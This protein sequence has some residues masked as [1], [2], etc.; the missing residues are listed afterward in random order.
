[1]SQGVAILFIPPLLAVCAG[2]FFRRTASRRILI[3][4]GVYFALFFA[5]GWGLDRQCGFND[6]SFGTCHV[7]PNALIGV[8]SIWHLYTLGA[9]MI[10][11]PVLLVW[12]VALEM[13]LRCTERPGG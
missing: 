2:C 11:A 3:Y 1:M 8:F 4:G 13:R 9:Y 12:A 7:L 10:V 5:V 6:F